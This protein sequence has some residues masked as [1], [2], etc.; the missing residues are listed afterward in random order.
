MADQKDWLAEMKTLTGVKLGGE[1][2]GYF[3]WHSNSRRVPRKR[4]RNHV[5]IRLA[6]PAPN[7]NALPV[8]KYEHSHSC[9]IRPFLHNWSS[10][11]LLLKGAT[12]AI[13]F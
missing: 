1:Y 5:R 9:Q 10:G 7:Q 8:A 6:R 13:P 3:T 2:G 12:V 11:V 4:A